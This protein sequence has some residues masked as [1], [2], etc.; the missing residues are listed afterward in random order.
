MKRFLALIFILALTGCATIP[1]DKR[2]NFSNKEFSD[3]R[4]KIIIDRSGK[5][6]VLNI[7]G[8]PHLKTTLKASSIDV[9]KIPIL[10]Q[11]NYVPQERGYT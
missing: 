2:Y 8:R 1:L 5:T 9:P 6:D 10:N 7:L 4:S 3:F 11:F